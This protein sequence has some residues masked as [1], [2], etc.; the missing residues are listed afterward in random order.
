MEHR[1]L[2]TNESS[3]DLKNKS[4]RKSQP[5]VMRNE[6]H[7]MRSMGDFSD[8]RKNTVIRIPIVPPFVDSVKISAA[9][10]RIP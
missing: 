4:L 6:N 3:I 9:N 1:K 2:M 8:T 10:L 5:R 7:L